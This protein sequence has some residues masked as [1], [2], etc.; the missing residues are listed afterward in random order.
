[1]SQIVVG[2][3]RISQRALL[4]AMAALAL[5]ACTLGMASSALAGEWVQRSCSFG[6]TEY[7]APEDWEAEANYGYVGLPPDNCERYYNGGGLAAYA[8][9]WN[10]TKP[11]SGTT[12]RYKAPRYAT[13]AGGDL[14]VTMTAR[15]GG[16][17]VGAKVKEQP[18]TLAVCENPGCQG[19]GKI[20]PITAS[21]A[22][23]LWETA[24]CF[25]N[26]EGIC[27]AEDFNEHEGNGHEA[28]EVN[29]TSAQIVLST[30]AA[31]AGSGFSG[32]LLGGTVTGTGTLNFKAT[33][34]GPGVYQARAKIDGQQVWAATPNLDEGKCVSTGS[35]EGVRAFDYAQP[36][37][38]ETAVH[39][40]INTA[41]LSDGTHA[42]TVEVEDAAGD[43]ATVYAGTLSTL[44]H[45]VSTILE[46]APATVP[47]RGPANGTPASESAVLTAQWARKS[48]KSANALTSTYG[49]TREITGKLTTTTGVPIADAL[50]EVSQKPSS[51]GAAASSMTGTHTN[52]QGVFTINVPPTSP[53]TSIQL[54]Y[55]SHLG[56]AQPAA[57]QTLTL[58]VP[59]SIHLT[60]SPH[61]TS[62]G[63]TIVLSGKLAGAIPPGGKKVL[64][65]AR[66]AGGSWIEFH[67]ATVDSHGRFRATHRFTF[68]GP[69]SY[70]FR[71]V[72]EREADFPFLAGNSNV[73][74]VW[75]R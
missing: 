56:D 5:A 24:Y 39:A 1:M 6:G 40:E 63:R 3:R 14:A 27:P 8:A 47:V 75:E 42:L 17:I 44:N 16:A 41:G 67:N 2:N 13:I 22:S 37:P 53:S 20:L 28:A 43:V 10:G 29:I 35:L 25:P 33:D 31:P 11:D 52:P 59:A 7:I 4:L 18:V 58:Q 45:L 70:Q 65:E 51:L 66:V 73:V 30:N 50:I 61:V 64:F 26:S 55:R 60:V 15:D 49:H 68:S 9:G 23:E 48:G 36:C 74:R 72:C 71:V 21:G 12:W 38:T 54:A 62:V 34:P 46:P 57:T 32:T 19:Y 69:I